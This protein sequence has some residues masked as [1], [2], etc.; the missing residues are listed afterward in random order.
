MI[1]A[2]ADPEGDRGSEDSGPSPEIGFPCNTGP[3]PLKN[4][5]VKEGQHSMLGH[6][7]HASDET[8]FK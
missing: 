2:C 7:R 3:D 1:V 6:H 4:H 8:P 5:K